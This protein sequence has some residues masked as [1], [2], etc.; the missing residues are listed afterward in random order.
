MARM[1]I[2]RANIAEASRHVGVD[3]DTLIAQ[4]EDMIAKHEG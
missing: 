4:I 1:L 2:A 3:A